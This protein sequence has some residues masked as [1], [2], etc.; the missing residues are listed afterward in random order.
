MQK[1]LFLIVTLSAAAFATFVSPAQG[2]NFFAERYEGYPID[3]L[4]QKALGGPTGK[5]E[6]FGSTDACTLGN[7]GSIKLGFS[8]EKR[9]FNGAG[10]DFIVFENPFQILDTEP[11]YDPLGLYFAE[12]MFVEVST[13]G[14]VFARFPM[15]TTNTEP[16][17]A[18]ETDGLDAAQYSGFAGIHPVYANVDSNS[19]DPFDPAVAGGDAFDLSDLSDHPN[20]TSG[21]V[22]LNDIRWVRLVDITGDG[23]VLDSE[24]NPI[25]DAYQYEGD[26]I[27]INGADVD[28]LSVIN[29][30]EGAVIPE[31][32]TTI[33]FIIS[34]PLFAALTGFFR[35]RNMFFQK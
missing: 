28:A 17:H 14:E 5:G 3:F 13:D 11:P 23:S 26:P 18:D 24:G 15:L 1:T 27:A 31:P 21:L 22:D 19:I 4:A 6:W 16:I 9:V 2:L 20:V 7:G 33:S 34:L 30:L 35:F 10:P 32:A 8:D 29:G 12:L 25:F